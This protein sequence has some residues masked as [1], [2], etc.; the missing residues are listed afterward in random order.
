LAPEAGIKILDHIVYDVNTVDFSPIY[1]KAVKANPD[2]I[3]LISSVKSQVPSSQYVKLQVPLP[4][5][6]VNVS[7]FGMEFWKDTGGMGGGTS[8]LIP[9]PCLGLDM[10]ARSQKFVDKYKAKY[11]SRP[12]FPHFNGF[13]AYYG[14]HNAMAAAER[15]TKIY[16]DGKL[17]LRYAYWKP[18]EIEPR[19]NR[20]YTHNIK[21]DITPPFEDGHPSLVV[22]QWYMDGSVKVVYPPKYASGEFAVPPWIK[23]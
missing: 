19:T 3:Y 5:T 21:F 23:K 18:G 13:N 16:K 11:T 2:F 12:V 10:D 22:I 4:M 9:A 1:N 7:A 8:T 6:G 14:I 20:E 17:W 15:A